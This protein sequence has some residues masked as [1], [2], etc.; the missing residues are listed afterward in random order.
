MPAKWKRLAG[1]PTQVGQIQA[2]QA[3]KHTTVFM[4]S[5]S[6]PGAGSPKVKA[7]FTACAAATLGIEKRVE[8]N[9]KMQ[10]CMAAK[11][12]KTGVYHRKSRAK[13]GSPLHGKVYT[14]GG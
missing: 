10:D 13:I 4:R 7:A 8:R 1:V 11:G 5:P 14:T 9:A 6:A 2:V 12:L 3:K